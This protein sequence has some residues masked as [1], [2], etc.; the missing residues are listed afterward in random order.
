MSDEGG[1]KPFDPTPSRK[2][3][4]IRDGNVARSSEISGLAS[5]A[6]A[7]AA[8]FG[9]IPFI[10]AAAAQSI[11]EAAHASDIIHVPPS[12]G[13]V[14][15]FALAPVVAA[16]TGGTTAGLVQS[17]GLRFT[18]LRVQF[19]KLNPFAGLKR[20]IGGEALLGAV[21]ALLAFAI[22]TAALWPLACE[23]FVRAATIGGPGAFGVLVNTAAQRAFYA[24]IGV[25][26]VFAVADYAL[27]R[28]R[29]IAD[30][31]MSHDDIK[32]D[33]REN[34]GD[35]HSRSRRKTFHRTLVRGSIQRTREASFVV[36][37]P[38]H[39]ALAIRYA[40]PRVPV[41]EIL[42]R[43]AGESA[44]T[45]KLL[46]IKHAIPIIENVPL[47]RALYA[48]GEPG[49]AIPSETFVAVARV[50]AELVRE[51]AIE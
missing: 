36:V 20:M 13:A 28:R 42:V 43:A 8:T 37:N 15:A 48:H 44:L 25:G 26:A 17:G 22:A 45:V 50:I 33:Q 38:T 16:A 46:A 23:M 34:D 11:R 32:R 5:F 40:P 35:P 49:H 1:Q 10:G 19:A 18:P 31:K 7:A 2:H 51:G 12:L 30:L 14:I 3:K 27:A 4:A 9:V 47:A 39:I 41:P 21:R 6:C 24:A 29:W